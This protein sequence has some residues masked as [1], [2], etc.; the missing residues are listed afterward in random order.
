MKRWNLD[1]VNSVF[2]A[3]I[4]NIRNVVFLPLIFSIN[5]GLTCCFSNRGEKVSMGH[6]RGIEIGCINIY[7]VPYRVE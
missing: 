2:V 1:F 5:E 4:L 7:F 6:F 3:E